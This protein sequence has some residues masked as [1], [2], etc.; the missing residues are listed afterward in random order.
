MV[1]GLFFAVMIPNETIKD[2]KITI[3]RFSFKI[4]GSEVRC[5]GKRK[6]NVGM[7]KII[8]PTKIPKQNNKKNL[9]DFFFLR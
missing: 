5:H 1:F 2:N 7:M 4:M 3:L 9:L 6:I 8:I